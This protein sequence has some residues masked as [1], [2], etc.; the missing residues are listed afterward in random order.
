VEDLRGAANRGSPDSR[1]GMDSI[2]R[3]SALDV[4]PQV[5]SWS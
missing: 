5:N 1:N 4:I 2:L 3:T